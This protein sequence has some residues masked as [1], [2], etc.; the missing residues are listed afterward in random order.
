MSVAVRAP[1]MHSFGSTPAG[2]SIL[3]MSAPKSPRIRTRIGPARTREMSSTRR[4]A[5][6]L[7]VQRSCQSS[8]A[9]DDITWSLIAMGIRAC[10]SVRFCTAAANAISA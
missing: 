6:A 7:T 10:Q 5:S 4:C 9:H 1:L 2:A 8:A 3:M